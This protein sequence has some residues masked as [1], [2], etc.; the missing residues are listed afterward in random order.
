MISIDIE[1]KLKAYQG[2]QVLKISGEFATCSITK[3]Y[4]PSGAGKTTFLKVIAGFVQP[5]KGNITVEGLTWLD[6][7][8]KISLPPQK[9]MAGFVFQDYALF[10]NMTVLQ[11]LQY[12]TKDAAWI[13]RLLAIGKLE[14]LATHKPEYLSGGQQQRLAIL[15]A[16]ATKPKFL[17]MDEPF[18]ALDPEMKVEL[19]NELKLIFN[20]L[21]TTVFIVSH[22]PQELEGLA[23]HEMNIH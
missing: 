9:R 2:Q 3:I 1:K 11:H 22:N 6:T 15:R 10:P 18:S 4:G 19:I 8:S 23:E 12:A 16:L 21:G 13:Q 14:T 17:L 5:E 20:E 7:A